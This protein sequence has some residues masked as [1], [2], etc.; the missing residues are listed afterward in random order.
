MKPVYALSICLVSFF[1]AAAPCAAQKPDS[2]AVELPELKVTAKFD[3]TI[4]T[5]LEACT[6]DGMMRFNVRNSRIGVRGTVG[7]YVAYRIQVELSAEGNFSPLD[8]FGTITPLKGLSIDFGQTSVPFEN[9]YIITPSEMLFANRAFIGK[10]FTPGSRDIGMVARYAFRIG[11]FP[12]EGQAGIFNGGKINN[13]QWTDN[14]SW[15]VRLIA[16]NM[17]GWRS[18][19]KAYSYHRQAS[20]SAAALHQFFLGAD[21][22]YAA[23]E[24]KIEAEVMN[25]H[26]QGGGNDLLGAYVQGA[27]AF[28]LHGGKIFHSVAPA[29]RWD[30]MGY[31]SDG[32]V[33]DVNRITAGVDFGL[34]RKPFGSVLRLDYEH[35][36]L[37]D[38]VDPL[39]FQDRDIH[40]ADNK[41]TLEL[42]VKF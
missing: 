18:S 29:L 14:P 1:C 4:K 10:F 34:S 21:I 25:R 8:L 20:A 32:S 15:A 27:Y 30:A 17:E 41:L 40:V 9:N 39:Y 6:E 12:M 2:A 3:G 16:G 31:P 24:Y 7:D 28:P 35:Y 11:S 33:F 42:V 38:G 13:P 22:R 37:R 19:V 36:F 5:K 26:P 23:K